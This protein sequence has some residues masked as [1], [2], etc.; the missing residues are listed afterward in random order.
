[1]LQILVAYGI[2]KI[3]IQK[4]ALTNAL[5]YKHTFEKSYITRRRYWIICNK[6][7]VLQG[8]TLA[9]FLFV[10]TLHYEMRQAMDTK[11]N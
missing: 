3:I 2:P 5:T 11:K 4:Y 9:T 1:M 6:K 8:D 10:I 7:A